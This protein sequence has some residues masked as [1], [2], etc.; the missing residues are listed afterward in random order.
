MKEVPR[1]FLSGSEPLHGELCQASYLHTY[2]GIADT[3][4][5]G[6]VMV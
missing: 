1:P 2:C 4:G 6:F 3:D 5:T